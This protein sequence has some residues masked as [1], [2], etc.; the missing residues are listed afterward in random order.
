[1]EDKK[2][3]LSPSIIAGILYS[4]YALYTLFANPG[5]NKILFLILIVGLALLIYSVFADKKGILISVGYALLLVRIVIVLF[6][7]TGVLSILGKVFSILGFI[8]AIILSF[9]ITSENVDATGLF[10][11]KIKPYWFAPSALLLIA[12]VLELIANFS[13]AALIFELVF[14]A[15]CLFTMMWLAKPEGKFVEILTVS[16]AVN[17]TVSEAFK[18]A[19]AEVESKLET[20]KAEIETKMENKVEPK[21]IV[22][23]P[24]I[25]QAVTP[26]TTQMKE[27]IT[28]SYGIAEELRIYKQLFDEEILTQDEFRERK[29]KVLNK[30]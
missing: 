23:K 7:T 11:E 10:E 24:V 12:M 19:K 21:K 17:E 5:E 27:E 20:A 26:A 30:W 6:S 28:I 25:K 22:G 2:A 4:L 16:D 15:A 18:N 9:T 8:A 14:A 3:T 13:V 29:K 1:M